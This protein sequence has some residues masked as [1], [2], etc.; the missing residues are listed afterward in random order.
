VSPITYP[1]DLF[2]YPIKLENDFADERLV[3]SPLLIKLENDLPDQP[4]DLSLRTLEEKVI[5]KL[6]DQ[7]PVQQISQELDATIYKIYSIIRKQPLIKI[8]D[9]GRYTLDIKYRIQEARC[10]GISS[11]EIAK[12]FN[13]KP[14]QVLYINRC[15]RDILME[16]LCHSVNLIPN[17][18][19]SAMTIE[20]LKALLH[21][22]RIL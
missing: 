10:L 17:G 20:K 11:K 3:L 8:K 21:R 2:S 7:T 4:F 9:F 5:Q 14:H 22:R 19:A 18:G 1:H 6:N 16:Q 15:N 13:L 12:I